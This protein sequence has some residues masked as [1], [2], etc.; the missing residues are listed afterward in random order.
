M[1]A[2]THQR[3]HLRRD[4]LTGYFVIGGALAICLTYSLNASRDSS[5]PSALTSF[6][7]YWS[8]PAQSISLQDPTQRAALRDPVFYMDETG[9]L[10]F[11]GYVQHSTPAKDR[12]EVAV[13]WCLPDVAPE[14]LSWTMHE[15][16][17]S[18]ADAVQ[19]LLPPDKR[20]RLEQQIR[21][22][23]QQHGAELANQL[24]PILESSIKQSIPV[25]ETAVRQ[26]V[27]KHRTELDQLGQKWNESVVR[28]RLVPLTTER[29]LPIVR[30]H[31]EPVAREVGE[32]LWQRASV[33]SF[34]WRIVYDKSPLPQKDLTNQE[35]DRF[36]NE[37]AIRF[38]K[39]TP[40]RLPQR[41]ANRSLRLLTTP[42]CAK[43]WL[44]RP[45]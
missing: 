2:R 16:G 30:K 33:W 3:I 6:V 27:A 23:M 11:A 26:S 39:L 43:N 22:A 21:F 7:R 14:T 9:K 12:R 5:R 17:G 38:S 28:Q 24:L 44:K 40:T 34:G 37:E 31:G 45:M 35:W 41:F 15:N 1:A 8:Q 25:I 18:F 36:V 29:M 19:L 13:Q 10:Q 20:A 42:R 4:R 32:E